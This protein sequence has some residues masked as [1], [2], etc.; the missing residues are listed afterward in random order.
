MSPS[1]DSITVGSAAA[2]SV[3]ISGISGRFPQ[4]DDVGDFARKLYEKRDLIDDLEVRWKHTIQGMPRRNGRMNN[5]E[6]F[7]AEFFGISH[8]LRDVMDP[9]LRM[10]LEHSYEAILDAGVNPQELRGSR[11]GVFSGHCFTETEN[12]MYETIQPMEGTGLLGC[13][14]SQNANRIS[15][16]LDLRGPSTVV[17]TACS[18]SLTALDVAFRS[19]LNG[20]CDA[21]LVTGSNLLINPQVTYQFALL[22]VLTRDGYCRPFDKAA[23]G[24]TRSEA[25]CA[26]F[27]QKLKDAKR[28]YGHVLYSQSNCDGFKKEGITFPSRDLQYQLMKEVYQTVGID[29]VNV[30]Y[31]EAHSTGTVVGDPE[32]C[33]A[34]DKLFNAGREGPL[35]V[36]SVKSSIGHTEAAAGVCSIV[37][38]IMAFEN[39]LIPPNINFNETRP[40]IPALVEGR[41]KVVDEVMPFSGSLIAINSFGF[42]GGNAHT[43]LAR[44]LKEKDNYGLPKDDLPRL[45]I[46]SG[47]TK[48]AVESMLLNISQHPLDVE[49]LGLL[50][51]I[52]R[53]ATPGHRYRGFAIY[54][55][56]GRKP[57]VLHEKQMVRAKLELMPLMVI[58]G[59]INVH[60]KRELNV[61][62]KFPQVNRTFSKCVKILEDLRMDLYNSSDDLVILNDMVG[63]VVLQ[64]SVADLFASIGIK[65][66]YFGGHSVGQF[67]CAYLDG[68]L[69]LEETLTLVY[70]HGLVYREI[71][72][73]YCATALVKRTVNSRQSSGHSKTQSFEIISGSME[74]LSEQ[75]NLKSTSDYKSAKLPFIT[76]HSEEFSTKLIDSKLLDLVKDI[77]TRNHVTSGAWVTRDDFNFRSAVLHSSSAIE[78]LLTNIPNHVSILD[79]NLTNSCEHV[80]SLLDLKVASIASNSNDS[81]SLALRLLSKIGHVY[82]SKAQ[83]DLGNLYPPIQFPVSRGTPMLSPLIKWDHRQNTYFPFS[84]DVART[85]ETTKLSYISL[86]SPNYKFVQG[87]CID[88]RVLFPATGYLYLAWEL[89]A[90]RLDSCLNDM[91]VEFWDVKF[92][93]ATTLSREKQVKLTLNFLS[94]SGFFEIIEAETVVV[95]GYIKQLSVDWTPPVIEEQT[96]TAVTVTARDFYKE[97]R[98]RGYHYNGVFKSVQEA[99]TDGLSSKVQWDGNWVAFLDGLLQTGIVGIDTRSLMIPISVERIQINPVYHLN[100]IVNSGEEKTV[101]DCRSCAKTKVTVAGG[102][103]IANPNVQTIARRL[104]P[105]VPVLESHQFVPYHASEVIS[106]KEIARSCVQLSIE[107]ILSL[108]ITAVE[109]HSQTRSTMV[110]LFGE[111]V[112]DLPLLRSSLTLLSKQEIEL[113]G[114]TVEQKSLSEFSNVTFLIMENI[115]D[116]M[117]LSENILN[118]LSKGGYLLLRAKMDFDWKSMNVPEQMNTVATFRADE[119]ELVIL[120]QKKVE[121]IVEDTVCIKVETN[122]LQWL[123]SVIE[124]V[125]SNSVI[126][127]SQNDPTSGIIGLVNCIRKEPNHQNVRCVFIDDETAPIFDLNHPFYEQQLRL[128]LPFNIY[129]NGEWGSYRHSLLPSMIRTEPVSHHCFANCLKKGDLSTMMWFNGALNVSEANTDLIQVSYSSLNFRDVMLATGRLSVDALNLSRLETEC[130]LGLE[131]SGVTRNGRRVMGVADSGALATKVKYHPYLVWDVPEDWSLEDAATVPVVYMTVYMAF[132][133]CAKIT[134]GKSVLIHAGSGGVGL[135]AIQTALSHGLEVFTTVGSDEKKR[136]LLQLFPQLNPENIGNSRN[137]SF[138]QMVK[139]RTNGKGV[140]Y[141]LNSLAEEKLQASVRCLSNGGHFLE[142]GKFDMANDSKLA[143]TL[144]QR[145]ITF[146]SVMLDLMFRESTRFLQTMH[147]IL[148]KSIRQGLVKPLRAT[149]YEAD[150]LEKAVR[151]L[152]SGKHIGKVLLKI[153]ER[154]M[155]SETLPISYVP[156]VYCNPEQVCIIVGGLGGFGMELADWLII[157]GCRKLVLSTSRGITRSYQ[158]Y[159]I[160]TWKGYGVEIVIS[161]AD[162]TTEDGCRN[163]LNEASK[164]G[165]IASIFHLAVRLRDAILDNQTVDKFQEVLQPKAYAAIHLDRLSRM[166]CPGLKGFVVFSSVSCGRG[167]A[168]QSNYGMANSIMERIVERRHAE[169]LP[170]KAIQWGAVGDV[171]LVADMAEDKIDME[172]GGTLQQRITSCLQEMDLLMTCEQ[173]IVAS[174][175]VAEKRTESAK[176][177]VEAVMHIMNIRDLKKISLES[178][179]PDMGMDSLMAVEIKQVLERDFEVV[180]NA[181]DLA[182]LTFEKLMKLDEERMKGISNNGNADDLVIGLE[183]LFRTLGIEQNSEITILRLGFSESTG[184]PILIIPGI[185]GVAGNIWVTIAEQLNAPVYIL[186]LMKT[187]ECQSASQVV[188]NV[189][190]ELCSSVI[191]KTEKIDIIGY[192]FGSLIALELAKRAA[193]KNKIERLMLVDG[194]PKL[195]KEALE[196][197]VANDPSDANIQKQLIAAMISVTTDRISLDNIHIIMETPTFEGKIDKM[198]EMSRGHTDY[199]PNYIRNLAKG[200]FNRLKFMQ[201]SN[202]N[203]SPTIDLP[204]TVVK[205]SEA[206]FVGSGEDYGIS[207][208]T[209]GEVTI[210]TIDGNHASMLL[211]PELIK[212][213]SGP[214]EG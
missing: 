98:L 185:E 200:I 170:A 61:L 144:F 58:F 87:H 25:V 135:A 132:F 214:T 155:D 194:S 8:L 63:T 161:T 175:V 140:D 62:R 30:G 211:N 31:V 105:G 12:H 42:G 143:M 160:E 97:L 193:L 74:Y 36:G 123:S 114:V 94:S 4:A 83:M 159:R 166:M 196:K 5:V 126:L 82:F 108:N 71:G 179:L 33:D 157:R 153:R 145:G 79:L 195:F 18:S 209:S 163:F 172:I 104:P 129:R 189:I 51:N 125:K 90:S 21:A 165:S 38:C 109:V 151:F 68:C 171:G 149:V 48:A 128:N 99:R 176:T 1:V 178:T 34:L 137:T 56:N 6:F 23:S 201:N 118:C 146:T 72:A 24:Y 117:V 180:L 154:E 47:R 119:N 22:G 35:L 80:V 67:T 174:M 186:Q 167:N 43:L 136:Y 2:D 55:K 95:T 44:N 45:V 133:S 183:I 102:V 205:A 15:Y 184:T 64:L 54:T 81:D 89:I 156:R 208:E 164:L 188:D 187:I 14:K 29:P 173:P 115:S 177:M 53:F 76:L 206:I 103:L 112:E 169:G 182:T 96:S 75:L 121:Q 147:G 60:W 40:D 69:S 28:V 85:R 7:D 52:Q 124:A 110:H 86:A 120:L 59:G 138:E 198:I 17:D 46:W 122:D 111:A 88:G 91:P 13:A 204:I 210:Q 162:V 41:L 70:K 131:F 84:K 202:E 212:I 181:K 27:L 207:T 26:V 191:D 10:L 142:I 49:F 139:L 66:D 192:S 93:R 134:K 39:G 20:E 9:Q 65:L 199:S 168:G 73:Q 16:S 113:P 116:E 127:Y 130:D 32:E 100:S 11:T 78:N 106:M 50:Y 92:M 197:A 152:A 190:D 203:Q 101:F 37:K 150:E 107:N 213:I 57:A 148:D 141:V 158:E 3:V 19:M 77:S